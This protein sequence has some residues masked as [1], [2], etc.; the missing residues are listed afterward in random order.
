MGFAKDSYTTESLASLSSRLLRLTPLEAGQEDLPVLI[1]SNLHLSMGATEVENIRVSASGVALELGDAG[2][3]D[4][5]LTFFSKR[6][7]TVK[8]AKNC[9]VTLVKNLSDHLWQVNVAGRKW[10]T[11]QSIELGTSDR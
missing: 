10:N 9:S 3:Q 4:G 1:G 5:T 8:G 11:A 6:R 7:L 2:A